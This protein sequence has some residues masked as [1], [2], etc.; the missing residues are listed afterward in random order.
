[1]AA[2]PGLAY[3]AAG[4]AG[5]FAVHHVWP[6]VSPLSMS[7]ALGALAANA[8]VLPPGARDGCRVAATRVLRAGV[9]LLGLRISI[10]D[11]LGLGVTTLAIVVLVV[12]LT[13]AG[14]RRLGRALG[15][16]PEL[17]LLVATGY[18]ICGAS[19]IAAVQGVTDAD[20]DDVGYAVALVTL[21]GT[22]AIVVLPPLGALVGLGPERFGAWVG[23]SVHD[24]GQVVAT[25]S[26]AGP[27]A[28]RVAVLVKLTRVA[29][30][31]PLVAGVAAHRRTS[32]TGRRPAIPGF[33]AA[34]L[35]AIAV[36][37]TG[38]VPTGVLDGAES[39]ATVLL[40]AGLVG[41]GTGIDGRR[42]RR[43]GGRPLALGLGAWVHV[44]GSSL[45]LV[46][47]LPV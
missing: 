4:V 10:G 36:R 43:L 40:A 35:A 23:A 30:L 41:L 1:V 15:A 5:A 12:V 8:G 44:G 18:A 16:G 17:S 21:C 11:A 33:V 45:L 31:A 47:L 2:A 38:V 46:H 22:L 25:A 32:P 7:V 42:L 27:D 20:E 37:T 28:L 34:F 19:A 6:G 24:V 3:V 26:T 39:L 9:A 29:L 13:F 14:T